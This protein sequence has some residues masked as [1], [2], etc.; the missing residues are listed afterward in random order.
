MRC[1]TVSVIP[2]G[3]NIALL[4]CLSNKNGAFITRIWVSTPSA[5]LLFHV[6]PE[7]YV[8]SFKPRSLFVSCCFC[9]SRPVWHFE[10]PHAFSCNLSEALW[11][12]YLW[13]CFGILSLFCACLFSCMKCKILCLPSEMGLVSPRVKECF[14]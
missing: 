14:E 1:L 6:C 2:E 9:G 3:I 8:W 4:T 11:G 10:S 13:V 5:R 12:C 7:S